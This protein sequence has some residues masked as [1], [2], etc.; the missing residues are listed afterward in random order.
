MVINSYT[1][2]CAVSQGWPWH[3]PGGSM[4]VP[5]FIPRV[6][7]HLSCHTLMINMIIWML[8]QAFTWPS[9]TKPPSASTC[10]QAPHWAPLNNWLLDSTSSLKGKLCSFKSLPTPCSMPCRWH[11]C[12]CSAGHWCSPSL[13]LLI[14]QPL[15][16][17][18]TPW[19]LSWPFFGCQTPQSLPWPLSEPLD[20]LVSSNH[21]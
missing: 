1:R 20:T 17:P 7:F 10:V 6:P 14:F 21:S 19:S 2:Y 15:S 5:H 9:S 18:Q 4:T 3:S 12:T 8:P 13:G 11:P 16:G